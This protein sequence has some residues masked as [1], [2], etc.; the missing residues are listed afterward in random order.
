MS[1]RCPLKAKGPTQYI[2]LHLP[3]FTG[4]AG[5]GDNKKG[6]IYCSLQQ[7]DV[8]CQIT[9]QVS[10]GAPP[11]WKEDDTVSETH[12]QDAFTFAFHQIMP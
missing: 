11:C 2:E 12:S 7:R 1:P 9:A 6:D 10:R 4:K 8:A 5:L 3:L